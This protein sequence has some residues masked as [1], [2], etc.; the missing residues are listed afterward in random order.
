MRKNDFVDWLED[1]EKQN[2]EYFGKV[3]GVLMQGFNPRF[4]YEEMI[5]HIW[6]DLTST[7]KKAYGKDAWEFLQYYIKKYNKRVPT[8][9]KL[10]ESDFVNLRQPRSFSK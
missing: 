1:I 7:G 8:H 2:P 10:K 5:S 3:W 9:F 4:F 6:G